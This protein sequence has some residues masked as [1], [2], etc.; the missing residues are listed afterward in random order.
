MELGESLELYFE[1]RKFFLKKCMGIVNIN[2]RDGK[3]PHPIFI[4]VNLILFTFFQQDLPLWRGYF[5]AIVMALFNFVAV[6]LG[7]N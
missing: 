6:M 2:I 3:K 5:Y 7:T 4:K 1:L